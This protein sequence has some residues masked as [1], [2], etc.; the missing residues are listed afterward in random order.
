VAGSESD[1]GPETGVPVEELKRLLA[2]VADIPNGFHLHKKLQ[3]TIERRQKMAAGEEPLD[4]SAAEALAFASL[5]VE[6]HLVRLSGQDSARGTFSH[7]HA[8]L[9]DVVDGR[10]HH[11][12][13]NL[14]PGQAR[15]DVINSPLC[16]TGTMGFEYGYS[17]DYP[18]G[19]VLWE[20]QY[21]DFVNAAQVIIDQFISSAED[22]WRRFSGLVLLLPH[23]FEGKGPEHSSARLERF[24][25][26][27]AEDNLQIVTPST[28]AQYFHCLRRQ[29]KRN[30]RK[31]LIVLTPKSL[32]RHPSVISPLDDLASN[33][34]ERILADTRQDTSQTSLVLLTSGKMYYDLVEAREKQQRGDVAILRVEQ[35]YPLRDETIAKA[36]QDYAPETPVRWVQEEPVNMGAWPFW[37]NRF[38]HRIID[39]F[40]FSAVARSA[41]A[42]PA[43]GSSAAHHR[44][45]EELIAR[46][47]NQ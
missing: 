7:R 40:P 10:L 18:E 47:F 16:E 31:P 20:A 32:L 33:R 34:F 17:L 11:V 22:K 30:W 46:A 38:C 8:V 45:Q 35:Y 9:H 2:K 21:G 5:A 23:A 13:R 14:A 39:K 19:L 36:L 1:D 27:A 6:G 28:P 25:F 12:F 3:R 41:S 42:S 24:L 37:K 44:E 26:L 15:V 43:T 29:V 4:W